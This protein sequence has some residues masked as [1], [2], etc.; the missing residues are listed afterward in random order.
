[1]LKKKKNPTKNLSLIDL[2]SEIYKEEGKTLFY[3]ADVKL[4]TE[5]SEL[6][7]VIQNL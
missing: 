2:N 6:P 4:I 7:R 1:M 5:I 3:F